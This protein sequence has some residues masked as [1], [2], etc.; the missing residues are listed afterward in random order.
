M[1][2]PLA[3]YV[4]ELVSRLGDGDPAALARLRTIVGVRRARVGLEGETVTVRFEPG[5]EFV[6]GAG[7]G[8]QVEGTGWT[9]H[10]V[11]LAVLAGALD[12]TDAVVDGMIEVRGSAEAVNAMF[13]AVEILIDAATRIPALRE[14]S[15][16][17]V[18][19]YSAYRAHAVN[20]RN[21]RSDTDVIKN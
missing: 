21:D 3:W 10:A 7:D 2:E 8:E 14:L 1:S 18:G 6:A 12:A 11:V 9:R 5:G 4:R 20:Q 16:Q 13:L 19:E 15:E 17:Y